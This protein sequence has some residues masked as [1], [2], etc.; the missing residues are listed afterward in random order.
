M[1]TDVDSTTLTKKLM[2]GY[3]GWFLCPG[4][5]TPTKAWIHWFRNNTPDAINLTIDMWPDTKELD[6]DE[7]FKTNMTHSDK[8]SAKLYSAHNPATV[9]RHFKWMH[10]YNLDGVMLQRFLQELKDSV[11]REIRD[12]ITRNV[13]AGAEAHG[14][15]FCIMY[16]ITGS[17]EATLVDDLKTDWTHLVDI[18]RITESPRYLRHRGKPLLA[19]WGLGFV[20]HP[21]T[22][23]QAQEI[24]RYFKRGSPSKYQVTLMGGVPPDWRTPDLDSKKDPGWSDVHRSF[25]VLSPWSVGRYRND[26][27]ADNFRKKRIVP[28]QAE[29]SRLGIDYMP[30]VFPGFSFR[31]KENKPLNE[32]PRRGGRFWW[33]QLYNDVSARCTMIYGAM[34]DEVDEGTAMFKLIANKADLPEEARESL[35]YLNID[36]EKLPSDWYLRVAAEGAKMLRGQIKL[37]PN[38]PIKPQESV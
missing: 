37:T 33:R 27:E 29:L 6:L 7:L 13:R 30:V 1:S 26:R 2:L 8:S 5:G 21:G 11:F 19:I 25:D 17:S 35:V 22:V 15:V 3:Q 20:D 31:N 18:L 28:D 12:Q 38:L 9:L 32:I 10:D 34:F 4:D 16:D 23:A 36:G 24:I 14:R